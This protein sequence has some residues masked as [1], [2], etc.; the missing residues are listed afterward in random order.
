MGIGERTVYRM[1]QDWK[2]QD[3]MQEAID[4][5]NDNMA[6][7]DVAPGRWQAAVSRQRG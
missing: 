3:Q 2:L 7:A 1:I 4:A 5:N 6:L